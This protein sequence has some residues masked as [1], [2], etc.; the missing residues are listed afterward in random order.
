MICS[1]CGRPLPDGAVF[2]PA[3]GAAPAQTP[4]GG[5]YY[6]QRQPAGYPP[7]YTAP[8]GTEPPKAKSAQT[9]SVVGLCMQYFNVFPLV[10]LILC[11]VG[12]VSANQSRALTGGVWSPSA[13]VARVC[14]IIGVVLAVVKA[15]AAIV[16]FILALVLFGSIAG[17]IGALPEIVEGFS[18]EFLL[19]APM[20][21]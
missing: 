11:I 8:I 1:N 15:V 10:G 9:M 14:G 12:M 13:K 2:C 5:S 16:L 17:L 21:N 19:I 20:I 7:A 6:P 4:N 18:E 3:C